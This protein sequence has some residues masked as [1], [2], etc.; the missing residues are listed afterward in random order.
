MRPIHRVDIAGS[1]REIVGECQAAMSEEI[2]T[3]DH[4][5]ARAEE[6]AAWNEYTDYLTEKEMR[7]AFARAVGA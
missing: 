2:E 4:I 6:C 1:V 5:I 3:A 7:G